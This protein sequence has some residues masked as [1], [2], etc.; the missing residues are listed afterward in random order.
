M[1]I[2]EADFTLNSLISFDRGTFFLNGLAHLKAATKVVYMSATMPKYFKNT[3]RNA[4]GEFDYHNFRSQYQICS[5]DRDPYKIDDYNFASNVALSDYL[6]NELKGLKQLDEQK[7]YPIIFFIE[8]W[9][10]VLVNKIDQVIKDVYG[11]ALIVIKDQKSLVQVQLLLLSQRIGA[12]IM[13]AS[14]GRGL[15]IKFEQDSQ[16]KVIANGG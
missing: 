8:E 9:D 12:V 14:F 13:P 11:K 7:K 10:N 1:I 16:V 3:I 2:D 4:F 15:N 6:L 5:G